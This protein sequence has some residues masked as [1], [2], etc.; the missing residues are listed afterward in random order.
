[1]KTGAHTSCSR[2]LLAG[3]TGGSNASWRHCLGWRCIPL[4]WPQRHPA[5]SL[6]GPSRL[7]AFGPSAR[8]GSAQGHARRSD[9]PH[10]T[11]CLSSCRCCSLDA[12][13]AAGLCFTDMPATRPLRSLRRIKLT[14]II[15]FTVVTGALGSAGAASSAGT[16]SAASSAAGASSSAVAGSAASPSDASATRLRPP[17]SCL[18]ARL[19]EVPVDGRSVQWEQDQARQGVKP[20]Q[21]GQR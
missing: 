16:A 4:S 14:F 12:S 1:M 6:A 2:N 8:S 11:K 10:S 3:P 19:A 20:A 9:E 7:S 18:G 17:T 13:A 15:C 5:T 21:E